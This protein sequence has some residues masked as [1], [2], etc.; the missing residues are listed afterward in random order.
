MFLYNVLFVSYL[1]DVFCPQFFATFRELANFSTRAA[2]AS[3]YIAEI[4]HVTNSCGR[5]MS[6]Q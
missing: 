3:T 5:K 1:C 2:Y 6:E 4:L